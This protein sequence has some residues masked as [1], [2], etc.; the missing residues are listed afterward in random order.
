MWISVNDER[1]PE[2][3]AKNKIDWRL[4]VPKELD[5]DRL[6]VN[7]TRLRRLARSG[8]GLGSLTV[9]SATLETQT[10]ANASVNFDGTMS[11]TRVKQKARLSRGTT[12]SA[13]NQGSDITRRF[14]SA[15]YRPDGTVD[16]DTAQ[17][18]DG[19]A[20]RGLQ[21]QPVSWARA[22]DG[23]IKSGVVESSIRSNVLDVAYFPE[24]GRRGSHVGR[25]F[26][27]ALGA[28]KAYAAYRGIED[29]T[30][31]VTGAVE[32]LD[33]A[34]VAATSM[35][36]RNMSDAVFY[37][38]FTKMNGSDISIRDFR[39]SVVDSIIPVD[40]VL[41]AGAQQYLSTPVVRYDAPAA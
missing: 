29:L 20:A 35:V 11:L 21:D 22:L 18:R 4:P 28:M 32:S 40:R 9:A 24:I 10:N 2:V 16:L 39:P 5:A 17:I 26:M 12:S 34:A 27:F 19:L 31:H 33:Y 25:T 8:G 41:L 15:Y 37:G 13:P 30:Q 1:A 23:A 36:F 6:M 7:P 14:Y 3:F 38:L